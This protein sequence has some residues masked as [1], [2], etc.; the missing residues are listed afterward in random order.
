[1]FGVFIFA[2]FIA[3]A[4]FILI[5]HQQQRTLSIVLGA[6]WV[7]GLP[8]YFLIE[9]VF[10]FRKYGDPTQYDQFKRVQDLATKIWVAAK[11]GHHSPLP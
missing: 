5:A 10:I 6:A 2:L 3:S 7:V 11:I 9:H 4:Y 1:M 8:I